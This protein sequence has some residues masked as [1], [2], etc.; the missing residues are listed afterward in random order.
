MRYT[1][2]RAVLMGALVLVIG[3]P[4]LLAQK[5]EINPYAGGVWPSHTSV[6]QLNN[7]WIYGVRAGIFLDSSFE[8]EG[9]WG[10]MNHFNLEGTS[11]KSRASLWEIAG[12]YNFSAQD[13]S[14]ARHFT[15]FVIVGVGAIRSHLPDSEDSSFRFRNPDN[16]RVTV[17]D[18]HNTF[19]NVSYGGGI[20][21]D[22]LWGPLGLRADV[23]GRTIPNYYHSAPTWL[24]VTGGFNLMWGER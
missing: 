12:D 13:W 9:Q 19:F 22:K 8:L 24:E 1:W 15:P 7:Q 17:I 21:S 18:E 2:Q 11:F 20:K 5:Y 16:G 10:Y 14:I 23:R 6:G 3:A 4:A